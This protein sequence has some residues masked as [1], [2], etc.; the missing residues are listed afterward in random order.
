MLA[1]K[2]DRQPSLKRLRPTPNRCQAR[3][4]AA[5]GEFVNSMTW[6]GFQTRLPGV[7]K[8]ISELG[9]DEWQRNLGKYLGLANQQA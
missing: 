4:Q 2:C 3:I 8:L 7:G 6:P 5:Y 1:G 9:V